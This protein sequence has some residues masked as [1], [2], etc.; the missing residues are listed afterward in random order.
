MLAYDVAADAA[1]RDAVIDIGAWIGIHERASAWLQKMTAR[2]IRRLRYLQ[3]CGCLY[4]YVGGD[5][6]RESQW[7]SVVAVFARISNISCLFGA[8][9]GYLSVVFIGMCAEEIV[10]P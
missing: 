6:G 4:A 8:A 5:A 3:C 1:S 9:L 2:G 7:D 10:L